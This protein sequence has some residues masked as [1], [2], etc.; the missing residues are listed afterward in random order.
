MIKKNQ[1]EFVRCNIL[2]WHQKGYTGKGMVAVVLDDGAKPYPWMTYARV[3]VGVVAKGGHAISVARVI[4][5][6]APDAEIVML[7]FI[8][9]ASAE[10]QKASIDWIIKNKPD[11]VCCSFTSYSS[12]FMRLKGTGIPCVC[13]S[14]ND[15]DN[16]YD[17]ENGVNCPANEEWTFSTGALEQY[18]DG[19]ANYSNGGKMLDNISYTDIWIPRVEKVLAETDTYIMSFNGTSCGAPMKSG[20]FLLYL[21]RCEE[22]G[23][24][25][26]IPELKSFAHSSVIDYYGVGFDYKSGHGLFILPGEIPL[27][28]IEL[29]IGSNKILVNGEEVFTDVPAQ[30]INGRTVLP[31][32]TVADALKAKRVNYDKG[33]VTLIF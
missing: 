14:G 3:E 6:V 25:P 33:V 32:R 2:K 23:Y 8:N 4:H 1:E 10:Q 19:I 18:H 12:E 31:L 7:P 11:V 9:G 27:T 21:Q 22:L 26:T 28:R 24:S 20:M 30:V 15:G 5:E 29:A 13:A 16:D 17:D